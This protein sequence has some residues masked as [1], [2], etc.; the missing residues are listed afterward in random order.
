MINLD[1]QEKLKKLDNSN[2]YGSV[3]ELAKQCIHAYDDANKIEVD[4]S[5]IRID[6][7]IM[8]KW[9]GHGLGQELLKAFMG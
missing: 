7:I 1:D 9:E 6:K 5:Y 2:T 3:E 4:Q 8:T